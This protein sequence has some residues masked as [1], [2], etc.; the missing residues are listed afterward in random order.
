MEI[1]A[2]AVGMVV[3]ESLDFMRT[4]TQVRG[5][6]ICACARVCE[7]VCVCVCRRLLKTVAFPEFTPQM[8]SHVAGNNGGREQSTFI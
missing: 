2:G 7:C 4:E 1:V 3:E 8:N 6:P 5:L